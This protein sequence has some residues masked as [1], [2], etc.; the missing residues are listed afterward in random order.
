MT[1]RFWIHFIKKIKVVVKNGKL[2]LSISAEELKGKA[3][4]FDI[5]VAGKK[6][7]AGKRVN[8]KVASDHSKQKMV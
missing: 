4:D 6:V 8:A 7:A 3:F 2:Y 5:E 1:K